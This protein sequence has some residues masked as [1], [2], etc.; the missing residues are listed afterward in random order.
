MMYEAYEKRVRRYLPLANTIKICVK[1]AVLL[2]MLA[3]VLLL[4]YLSLRGIYFGD[5][6]LQSDTV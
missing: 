4:G 3:A 2:L 5:L 1:C 6:S